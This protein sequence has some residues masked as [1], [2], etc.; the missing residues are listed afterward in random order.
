MDEVRNALEEKR[1]DMLGNV[2]PLLV[3][4]PIRIIRNPQKQTIKKYYD[5]L[6]P[7]DAPI[8]AAAISSK[9]GYLLTLDKKHFLI[10]LQAAKLPLDV[11]SPGAFIQ[12]YFD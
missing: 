11:L 8:L 5:I 1:S 2:K 10:P 3:H 4:F 9:S 12:R 7:E 6:P